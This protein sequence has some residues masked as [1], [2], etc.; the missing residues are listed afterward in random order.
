MIAA[1]AG[2]EHI[3]NQFAS[4]NWT[5][6]RNGELVSVDDMAINPN[7]VNLTL[8][9][10][11]FIPRRNANYVDFASED[12]LLWEEETFTRFYLRPCQ[13]FLFSTAERIDCTA[14]DEYGN[15]WVPKLDGRSSVGRGGVKVHFT[16][17]FGDYGFASTWTLEVETS[18]KTI[19]RPGMPLCQVSFETVLKP[20][21]YNGAYTDQHDG[22]K[23]PVYGPERF[24]E[25]FQREG[26]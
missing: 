21:V 13:F 26:R 2:G 9:N 15:L 23:A 8:S 25:R 12:S 10:K 5:M 3:Y 7:S 17:G 6:H 16:A 24:G 20:Y 22:P 14:P 11:V 19:L 1:L 4:G 18:F